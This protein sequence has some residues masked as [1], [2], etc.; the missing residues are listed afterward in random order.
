MVWEGCLQIWSNFSFAPSLHSLH[1]SIVVWSSGYKWRE[2]ICLSGL[3]SHTLSLSSHI[4]G[5]HTLSLLW[6]MFLS[7]NINF[8]WN[9]SAYHYSTCFGHFVKIDVNVSNASKCTSYGK[10]ERGHTAQ[11]SEFNLLLLMHKVNRGIYFQP[12]RFENWIYQY[13]A[14]IMF[15][16]KTFILLLYGPD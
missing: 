10:I 1:L 8:V 12:S 3:L 14:Q 13:F 7:W 11:F 4:I 5:R 9:N 16:S 2:T 6:E 15:V